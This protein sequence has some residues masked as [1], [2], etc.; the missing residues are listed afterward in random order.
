MGLGTE[1]GFEDVFED[2]DSF[3][4]GLEHRDGSE[5]LS[6]L[7]LGLGRRGVGSGGDG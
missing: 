4:D 7:E 6:G 5:M 3:E 1:L 2:G